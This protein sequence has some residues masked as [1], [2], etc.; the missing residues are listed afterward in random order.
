M[1]ADAVYSITNEN[2]QLGI[3][4]LNQ[5]GV[6]ITSVEMALFEMM[7]VAEGDAFRQIV[8]IVK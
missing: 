6:R 3:E 4:A 2:K 8:K 7:Q 5:V 1:V